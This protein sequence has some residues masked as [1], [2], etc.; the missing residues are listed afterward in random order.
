LTRFV[1][2]CRSHNID[3]VVAL[4][5]LNR[6]IADRYNDDDLKEAVGRIAAVVPVWDFGAPQWLT[7]RSDLW[8]DAGH[9]K[10]EVAIM[11]LD[12]IFDDGAARVPPDFGVL[13]RN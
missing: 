8:S 12:R 2:L 6:Y 4:S 7:A 5:P 11:M 13:R 3:L 10:P 1:E 9:F